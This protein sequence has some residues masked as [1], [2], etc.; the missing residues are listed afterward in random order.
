MIQTKPDV[1]VTEVFFDEKK[2][3][4]SLK[5]GRIIGAPLEWYPKLKN[6]S[7]GE[8]A[9]YEISPSGYGVHWPLI[10]EDL[11]ALGILDYRMVVNK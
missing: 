9:H 6:A 7:E 1:V 10:D 3:F 4:F 11:S 5:D 2:V 8:K